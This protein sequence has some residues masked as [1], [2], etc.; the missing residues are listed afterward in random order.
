MAK[1]SR[2]ARAGSG[3]GVQVAPGALVTMAYELYDAE[4][5]LVEASDPGFAVV[6]VFGY[7]QL[8]PGLERAVAGMSEGQVRRIRLKPE[9]AFG[10]RD[11]K[12]TCE[13]ARSGWP[14]GVGPG[15]E[16]EAESESG[17]EVV[18]RVLDINE[19]VA[20]L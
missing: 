19:D 4:G 17:G 2:Q 16:L 1:R 13:V 7:G 12:A 18:L 11:P 20:V 14:G 3:A 6:F 8:S 5:E 10:H 15:D 9:E